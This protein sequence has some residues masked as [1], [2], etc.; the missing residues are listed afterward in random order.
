MEQMNEIIIEEY[1]NPNLT[2][3]EI[4]LFQNLENEKSEN[5]EI[6]KLNDETNSLY[7]TEEKKSVFSN[8]IKKLIS[9]NK[10]RIKID[11]FDLDLTYITKKIIAMGL[12][13]QSIESF[14][15]NNITDVQNF[16]KKRHNLH[17]K[18]YNLCDDKKYDNNIFYKQE[19][20]PFQDHESPPLNLIYK[21]CNDAKNFL[22]QNELNVV[23]IHCKAGKGRTGCFTCCLLLYLKYFKNAYDCIKYYGI[24]RTDDGKGLTVPSQIRYV[25]YWEK[26]LKDENIIQFPIKF[27]TLYICN[28]KLNSVPKIKNFSPNVIIRNYDDNGKVIR[29]YNYNY[30]KYFNNNEFYCEFVME[31]LEVCGDV[32]FCFYHKFIMKNECVFK[33]WVNTYF[34]PKKGTYVIK[35]EMIDIAC[36][37][38]NED[39]YDH[40][41]EIKLSVDNQ[42]SD[43]K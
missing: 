39:I 34:L 35:K 25:Y 33:F 11:G 8:F 24:R 13:S 19:S 5:P 6:K 29:E 37:D 22:L 30:N 27:P 9:Q 4:P 28:I 38:I 16:F 32:K 31:N 18:V 3:K 17:H 41:F 15:R 7:K 10:N 21:F 40:S 43:I 42:K 26:I 1:K 2:I 14:Y 20:F 12:P 23:A 36:K